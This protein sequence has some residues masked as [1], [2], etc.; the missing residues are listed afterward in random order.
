MAELR[1]FGTTAI[2]ELPSEVDL[3]GEFL[4]KQR[5]EPMLNRVQAVEGVVVSQIIS[6]PIIR[7]VSAG[8]VLDSSDSIRFT[9]KA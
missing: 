4:G 2:A 1:Q 6:R 7:I 3:R 5:V 8:T 9:G